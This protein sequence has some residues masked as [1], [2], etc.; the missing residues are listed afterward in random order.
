M[1][2]NLIPVLYIT[3]KDT[4]RFSVTIK[5]FYIIPPIN[6]KNN[7][8]V[9]IEKVGSCVKFLQ[10]ELAKFASIYTSWCQLEFASTVIGGC[11]SWV[12]LTDL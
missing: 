3:V 4:K 11:T 8:A 7:R 2:I 6:N 12:A 9:R 1:K 5:V 10:V